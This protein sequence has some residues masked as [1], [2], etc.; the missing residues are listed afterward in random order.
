MVSELFEMF[1]VSSNTAYNAT[2]T[3]ATSGT[4]LIHSTLWS[5]QVSYIRIPKGCAM[6]IWES[7]VFAH[8]PTT[9]HIQHCDTSG[10]G[11]YMTIETDTVWSSG[12]EQR[13]SRSGRPVVIESHDGNQFVQFL[14][15]A[16][17]TLAPG[18]NMISSVVHASYNTEIVELNK[19]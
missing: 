6:K 10:T 19:D 1:A 17:F 13:T 4:L 9:V 15:D 2:A 16:S 3:S 8:S 11:T 14:Y 12:S 18:A 7:K 5:G